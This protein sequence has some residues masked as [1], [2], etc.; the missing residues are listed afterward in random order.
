MN[1]QELQVYLDKMSKPKIWGDGIML[2]AASNTTTD[3]SPF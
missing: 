2:S 3:P 1:E